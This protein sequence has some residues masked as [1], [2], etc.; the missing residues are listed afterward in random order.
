MKDVDL[1]N[2]LN[3]TIECFRPRVRDDLGDLGLDGGLDPF[4]LS[5]VAA[6]VDLGDALDAD[7]CK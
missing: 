2:S 1:A 4:E 7:E 6:I 5:T 3:A